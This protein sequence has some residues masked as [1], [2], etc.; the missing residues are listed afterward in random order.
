MT[1]PDGTPVWS[2]I[3]DVLLRSCRQFLM[4]C[5]PGTETPRSK[6]AP[7]VSVIPTLKLHCFQA[8]DLNAG[9]RS[10]PCETHRYDH[11]QPHGHVENH[12]NR[13]WLISKRFQARLLN[14]GQEPSKGPSGKAKPRHVLYRPYLVNLL[15]PNNW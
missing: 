2:H 14:A 8:P 7:H 4:V 15:L 6:C 13:Q 3:V 11:R 1:C 12:R 9:S 10:P 5:D